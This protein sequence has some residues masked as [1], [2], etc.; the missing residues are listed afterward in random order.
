MEARTI[1]IL[2]YLGVETLE[3]ALQKLQELEGEMNEEKSNNML[4]RQKD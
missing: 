3:E 1:E 4:P 2:N